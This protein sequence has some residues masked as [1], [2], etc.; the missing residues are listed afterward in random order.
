MKKSSVHTRKFKIIMMT[1]SVIIVMMIFIFINAGQFLLVKELPTEVDVIIVL[2]GGNGRIEKAVELYKKGFAPRVVISNSSQLLGDNKDMTQ[3]AI[4]LGIPE[5]AIIEE[6]YAQ[7]TM[8]NAE[9]TH[10]ILRKNGYASAIVISSDFHMRR[11]KYLF[12]REFRNS[13]VALTYVGANSTYRASKW[14]ANRDN[15]NITINEYIKL[16]G[17]ILGYHGQEAKKK[18]DEFNNWL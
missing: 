15:W 9:L 6:K 18:L 16:I 14:W 13:K 7:S 8:E 2:S 10:S 17:N 4:L 1:L 11:V 3:T 5:K 12:N